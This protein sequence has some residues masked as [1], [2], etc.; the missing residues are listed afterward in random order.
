ML[1]AGMPAHSYIDMMIYFILIPGSILA[2]LTQLVM[3]G[4]RVYALL[5]L[6][7]ALLMLWGWI[8]IGPVPGALWILLM[9]GLQFGLDIDYRR[10]KKGTDTGATGAA[11]Y[12][13]FLP[14]D[15]RR[16]LVLVMPPLKKPLYWLSAR[17]HKPTPQTGGQ[18]AGVA[19]KAMLDQVFG[20]S[21]GFKLDT[22]HLQQQDGPQMEIRCD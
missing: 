13:S 8:R 19:L 3:G 15:D 10:R 22:R 20:Q 16:P 14:H 9:A 21:R 17:M 18:P 7:L 2:L 6:T 1:F 11:R 12:L 4:P 5:R